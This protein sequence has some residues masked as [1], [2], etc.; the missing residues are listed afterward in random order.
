[1][2][3]ISQSKESRGSSSVKKMSLQLQILFHPSFYYSR[4]YYYY[5]VLVLVPHGQKMAAVTPGI[6]VTFKGNKSEVRW[7]EKQNKQKLIAGFISLFIRE[8]KIF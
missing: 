1:M 6:M 5:W 3:V 2:T 7:P 4:K 8:E